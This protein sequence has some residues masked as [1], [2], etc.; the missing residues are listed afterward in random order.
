MGNSQHSGQNMFTSDIIYDVAELSKSNDTM[1]A[2]IDDYAMIPPATDISLPPLNNN[3]E[4]PDNLGD[5]IGN[6]RSPNGSIDCIPVSQSCLVNCQTPPIGSCQPASSM[7]NCHTPPLA[8]CHTPVSILS[9]F[10]D[11]KAPEHSFPSEPQYIS[12]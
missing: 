5:S 9:H 6:C 7:A 3:I 4:C 11:T 12:L 2:N 10:D 8:S 1:K